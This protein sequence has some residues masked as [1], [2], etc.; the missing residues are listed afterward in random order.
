MSILDK[1]FKRFK[2]ILISN[3]M[4]YLRYTDSSFQVEM[5]C[6]SYKKKNITD[7]L[8]SILIQ[9]LRVYNIY[10]LPKILIK[11]ISSFNLLPNLSVYFPLNM[12]IQGYVYLRQQLY[13][14]NYS[15]FDFNIF[16]HLWLIISLGDKKI[17]E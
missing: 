2:T 17:N 11:L 5:T 3:H 7:Y 12:E 13:T 8:S 14:R 15:M 9:F 1:R 6:G 4:A 16:A 10:N